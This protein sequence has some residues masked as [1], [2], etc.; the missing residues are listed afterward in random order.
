MYSLYS[1]ILSC[2]ENSLIY[3]A[4]LVAVRRS[5][6]DQ[7]SCS[8]LGPVSTGIGDCIRVQLP[9][10]EIYLGL[11]NH[12]GQLSLAIP[13]WV[14][15]MST[16]QRAVMLSGW[17]VKAG[18]ARVWWQVKLC[19]PLYN[20]SYLSAGKAK[21]LRLSTVQIHD[22]FTLLLHTASFK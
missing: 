3:F 16:G 7:R 2:K 5:W 14:A 22:Y 10:W 11:T 13:S 19:E 20:T 12:P 8:T 6:S 21:L 15:A 17:G 18:M 1:C 9:V 4:E